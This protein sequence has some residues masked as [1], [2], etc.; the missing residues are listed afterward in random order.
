MAIIYH[1]ARRA[2]W[3]RARA[4]GVYRGDTLASEGFIHCSTKD[5]VVRVANHLFMGRSGLALLTIDES[6]LKSEVRYEA[7]ADGEVFPH[8]YGP[9]NLD[10]VVRAQAFEPGEDGRFTDE[11][12]KVNFD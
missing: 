4:E 10:A 3:L 8:I 12:L 11:A 9:I 1:I 5:Q 7:A 2:D 6:R